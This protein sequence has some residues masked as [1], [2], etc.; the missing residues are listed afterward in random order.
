MLNYLSK[1]NLN[2]EYCRFIVDMNFIPQPYG[3]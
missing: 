1:N 2:I 3:Y